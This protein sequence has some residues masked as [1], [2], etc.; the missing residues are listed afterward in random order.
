MSERLTF[1]H[2][3]IPGDGIPASFHWKW[4]LGAGQDTRRL[5]VYVVSDQVASQ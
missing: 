4:P 2:T 5:N 3:T 1:P